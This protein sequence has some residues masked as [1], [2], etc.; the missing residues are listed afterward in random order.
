MKWKQ[1]K[2]NGAGIFRVYNYTH[3]KGVPPRVW[4][5]EVVDKKTE[6]VIKSPILT[7]DTVL[8][9][10]SAG[11]HFTDEAFASDLTFG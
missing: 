11:N 2:A 3:K 8:Q 4:L 1:A 6:Q 10:R 5:A 7:A 9:L